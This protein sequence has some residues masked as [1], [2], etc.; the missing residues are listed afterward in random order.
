VVSQFIGSPDVDAEFGCGGL[1]ARPDA[2]EA[3]NQ[4]FVDP[5]VGHHVVHGHPR[6]YRDPE[7]TRAIAGHI[8]GGVM[9]TQSELAAPLMPGERLGPRSG[10][11]LRLLAGAGW[12]SLPFLP[13]IRQS[14]LVLAGLDDSIIP[15]IN[16]NIM[17]SLLPNAQLH[18]FPDAHLGI[19]TTGHRSRRESRLVPPTVMS[20]TPSCGSVDGDDLVQL[21]GLQAR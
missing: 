13:L 20:A 15:M 5:E 21:S 19:V 2:S 9:R 7:Y 10:Y 11:L 17:T 6:R 18:A 8:Y 12:T 3:D 4:A 16:A 1:C 14:T